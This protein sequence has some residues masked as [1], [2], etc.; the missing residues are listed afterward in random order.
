LNP[1][2]PDAD[3][4]AL[5]RANKRGL[6]YYELGRE[7]D[8]LEG[9]SAALNSQIDAALD[10]ELDRDGRRLVRAWR[11]DVARTDRLIRV[12]ERERAVYFGA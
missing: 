9:E 3:R 10:G 2:C 8:R 6:R 11:D 7:I 12:L 4:A 5:A 1:V